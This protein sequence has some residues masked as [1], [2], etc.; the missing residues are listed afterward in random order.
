MLLG[1]A[2]QETLVLCFHVLKKTAVDL[3]FT[4]LATLSSLR[5]L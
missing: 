1:G 3:D 4:T 2:K 5:T